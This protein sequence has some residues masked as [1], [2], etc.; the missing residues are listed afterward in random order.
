MRSVSSV[1]PSL[2]ITHSRGGSVWLVTLRI[3][4]PMVAAS[5]FTGVTST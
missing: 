5:F 3:V 4:S 2:A 1:E